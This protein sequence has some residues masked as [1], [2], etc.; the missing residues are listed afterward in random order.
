MSGSASVAGH[1]Q[2]SRK[3]V[4]RELH[5]QSKNSQ[6]ENNMIEGRIKLLAREESKM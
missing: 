1:G 4:N 5:K 6:Q 2:M 3:M